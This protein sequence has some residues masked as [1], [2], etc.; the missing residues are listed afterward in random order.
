MEYA[1][2]DRVSW[3]HF[4]GL[5]G[6]RDLP[7]ARTLWAFKEQLAQA[8]LQ[9]RGGQLIDATL[10]TVPKAQLSKQEKASIKAGKTPVH[11]SAKQVSHVDT[12]ARWITLLL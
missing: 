4:V 1:L 11:W 10:I 7:D 8:R 3:Q 12:D 5:A 2:L 9:A 6:A